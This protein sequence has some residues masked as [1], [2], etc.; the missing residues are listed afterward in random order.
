MIARIRLYWPFAVVALVLLAWGG[1]ALRSRFFRHVAAQQGAVAQQS[2]EQATQHA[3]Q[4]GVHD[5]AAATAGAAVAQ[6]SQPLPEDKATIARLTRECDAALALLRAK[7]V[8]PDAPAQPDPDPVALPPEVVDA[9]AKNQQLIQALTVAG[10]HKDQVI[11]AQGQQ[12]ISLTAARDS[13]RAEAEDSQK[14]AVAERIAHQA[15][16]SAARSQR[17]L[18]RIEGLVVGLSG[19]YVA[20]RVL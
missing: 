16:E 14:E 8:Q 20:G 9:L 17:L 7:P 3:A 12:I 10:E 15:S 6:A 2:H 4:G 11:A 1:N 5:Q 19:G 13:W 18:G